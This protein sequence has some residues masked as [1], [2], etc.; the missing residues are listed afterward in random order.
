[1][2]LERDADLTTDKFETSEAGKLKMGLHDK[3]NSIKCQQ[4]E[5]TP[6]NASRLKQHVLLVHEKLKNFKCSQCEYA[7]SDASRLRLHV[8]M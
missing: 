2:S 3:M 5:Y 6:S 1:M 8:E 4:C 7:A